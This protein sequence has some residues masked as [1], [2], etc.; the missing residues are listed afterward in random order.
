MKF[1][2]VLKANS[3][4][5]QLMVGHLRCTGFG[6]RK[7]AATFR[8][9]WSFISVDHPDQP[10]D[11][12]PAGA[13]TTPYFITPTLFTYL[14]F[15]YRR[16]SWFNSFPVLAYF[17]QAGRHYK[18]ILHYSNILPKS[19]YHRWRIVRLQDITGIQLHGCVACS[20]SIFR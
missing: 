18:E 12:I 8:K 5:A 20:W 13:Y 7:N 19:F 2:S 10:F 15:I 16:K 11:K 4:T 1:T 3:L 9:P 17:L 14:L 6:A